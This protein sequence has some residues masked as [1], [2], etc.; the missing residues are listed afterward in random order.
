MSIDFDSFFRNWIEGLL[1]RASWVET[2]RSMLGLEGVSQVWN[3]CA[4]WYFW[5]RQAPGAYALAV[6]EGDIFTSNDHRLYEGRFVLKC[7]PC[8]THPGFS[9]FSPDERR[10][11]QSERFDATHTPR[12]E[13][14]EAI[15]DSL[16]VVG[17]ISLLC[18]P[19][20]SLALLTY[21][22]L[23]A[24]RTHESGQAFDTL[25][26]TREPA[27]TQLIRDVPGWVI[28]YPLFDCLVGL[29][30]HRAKRPPTFIGVARCQGFEHTVFAD[31]KI[32]CQPSQT[33]TQLSLSIGFDMPGSDPERIETL[34]QERLSSDEEI[35]TVL[36][37]P[38]SINMP[39]NMAR[40]I[41][42]VLN[43][44]WWEIAASDF[45][46][47]LNSTCGCGDSECHF[48]KKEGAHEH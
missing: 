38:P 7:Y 22:S 2:L 21:Q 25:D 30:A 16:F 12:F 35:Q 6:S 1:I 41:D 10:L 11:V 32:V 5:L 28:G 48:S 29:Y 17:G 8:T 47:D 42:A 33:A 27:V 23:D 45:K 37:P 31:R 34:W 4:A 43:P 36:K 24:L 9:G 15:S 18:D 44:L 39:P 46:S 26:R 3:G 20:E 19:K 13:N 40:S 14:A